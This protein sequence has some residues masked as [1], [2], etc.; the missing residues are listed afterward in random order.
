M[1]A[2][3][4]GGHVIVR[5]RALERTFAALAATT[6]R[7][8]PRDVSAKVADERGILRVDIRTPYA[9]MD[10]AVVDAARRVQESVRSE[11][12]V[13]TGTQ[14]GTVTVRITDLTTTP[15]RTLA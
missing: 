4:V 10:A 8:P 12:G 5:G 13:L 2:T 1:S 11:G 14:I 7:V 6:L 15:G 3:T 9:G